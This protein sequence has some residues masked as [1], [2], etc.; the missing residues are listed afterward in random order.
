MSKQESKQHGTTGSFR[1]LSNNLHAN[2]PMHSSMPYLVH[3]VA[4]PLC[5]RRGKL[6]QHR[7]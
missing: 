3:H 7:R 4:D 1:L 5:S 6:K 2:R